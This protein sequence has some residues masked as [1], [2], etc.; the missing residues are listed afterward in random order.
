M[1]DV[2]GFVD[3]RQQLLSLKPN[4]RAHW[5]TLAIAHHINGSFNVAS[6]VR[7]W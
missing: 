6:E 1:R 3:T 4:N 2:P 5:V 7:P